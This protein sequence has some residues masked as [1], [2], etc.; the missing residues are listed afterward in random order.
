[1]ARDEGKVW[2]V[3]Y[4]LPGEVVEAEPR[5]RQGG[6]AVAATTR[7]L[8]PSPHR[9]AAPCPYFGTCGG[10]QLQHATYTHQ[11]DLKRQ[12]VAEAWA[13]AGLRLPP[14]AAVLGMED[15]WRY[16]IRG[17]FEAVAEA[18]GWRFGFHRMRSHAVL[19]VDS[20]AI[21]DERIERALPAFARAANELR[22]TGLQNLLLTVEPAGRGLLWRLRENSKGW[23]HD[24]YA[25]RVAELLPDAA[26]LDDAMSLDFWDMTFRVRSDTFVQTNYRQMLVLYRAALDMLQPMPE[27]RVLDLYAGIGTI[28]VAVARGCRSV[29]AVEENPRAVQLGRLNARINSARVEYLPGKVEDVL[30][31]VRLGQHDAVILDP[32]RAGCEPAAIA[33]LV[34]LGAGRVVYVSCEPSTHARD[35]AALVRGGYRV[36]RAAIVDMFPQTYHIESVALLERS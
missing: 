14:D 13:R 18:R 28:S 7:V 5:G 12:V 19:P 16:R 26:L 15:P 11:L 22:L 35:I 23:L 24:E 10:C 8:E 17:E 29:T 30:R 27:E 21:H 6:V 2:L 1:M 36:R 3:S 34:R 32:P 25:H 31:G 20:C 33:E 9:V 4:A